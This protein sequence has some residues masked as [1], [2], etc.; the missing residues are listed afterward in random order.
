[1]SSSPWNLYD[2]LIDFMD[3]NEIPSGPLMLRDFGIQSD[4]FIKHDYLGHK[5]TAIKNILDTYPHLNF[6][7]IGDSGERD[8]EIYGEVIKA[9]PGRIICSYIRDVASKSETEK[10]SRLLESIKQLNAPML[11]VNDSE[12]AAKH[13]TE[14]GLIFREEMNEIKQDKGMDEGEIS[15]KQEIGA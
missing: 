11:F 1:M 12:A 9:F 7:L 10:T 15:G 5:F 6:V 2:L 13:A 4:T 14:T 3:L 8:P